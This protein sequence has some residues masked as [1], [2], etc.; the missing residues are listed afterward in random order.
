MRMSEMA[1]LAGLVLR[2]ATRHSGRL[3]VNLLSMALISFVLL[4]AL[5]LGEGI[6]RE[7]ARAAGRLGADIMI[8]P[9]GTG[10]SGKA[11]L[12]GAI[13][14]GSTL[15]TG[16]EERVA[17]ITGISR[18]APQYLLSSAADPCCEMGEV[19]LVGFDPSR[20]FTVQPWLRPQDGLPDNGR[21]ILAG[22]RVM[23]APGAAM[24]FFNQTFT[25]TARLEQ[26]RSA[27][28]DT[29]LFIPLE[30]LASM[31]RSSRSGGGR[32][33]IPWGSPS[34]LLL[35]LASGIEP[36]QMALELERQYPGIQALPIDE[37]LRSERIHLEGLVSGRGPFVA[38]A[39]LI[40][41]L[42][43]GT[44]LLSNFQARRPSL[45]LLC[46]YGYGKGLLA[47]MFALETFLLSLAGMAA[48][49]VAAFFALGLSAQYLA[50]ATGVPLGSGWLSRSAAAA[51]WS[52]PA[53]AGALG[54]T[55]TMIVLF[56]LRS[57]PADLL[58]GRG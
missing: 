18:I 29:A 39:W 49:G 8:V 6:A 36:R 58:R 27:T 1:G 9:K 17:A 46:S 14:V 40:A 25:L 12:L 47:A 22:A 54:V 5:L 23:K 34:L 35:R 11:K 32:L 3:C 16:I 26:S 43:G 55:A 31:E 52:L 51:S 24:R 53:F 33:S 50:L 20:D 37:A 30:G 28:F 21:Q 4:G 2:M 48:G 10:I 42:S 7:A 56:M 41:L 19:L 45:G 13:P 38:T 44:L 15:P 57:E